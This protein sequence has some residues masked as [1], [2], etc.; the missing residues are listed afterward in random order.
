ATR[1]ANARCGCHS[2]LGGDV[3]VVG[4]VDADPRIRGERQPL[5]LLGELYPEI[6]RAV[7]ERVAPQLLLD[8]VDAV[9]LGEPRP[10][11]GGT[12]L[13][14]VA[15]FGQHL[16]DCRLVEHTGVGEAGAAVADHTDTDTFR[17][18]RDE[19]LD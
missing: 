13:H 8:D 18:G 7:G 10:F 15:S 16:G 5:Q 17:L 9:E 11:V 14:V 3:G 12:E 2:G 19:V 4:V 6:G 1:S